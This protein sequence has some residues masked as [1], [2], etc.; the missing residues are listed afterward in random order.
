MFKPN[1]ILLI[2]TS[3]HHYNGTICEQTLNQI[4]EVDNPG[5]A[6]DVIKKDILF[7]EQVLYHI[8]LNKT[9]QA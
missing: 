6:V 7:I 9:A 1:P 5:S 8:S 2:L 3:I 4:I